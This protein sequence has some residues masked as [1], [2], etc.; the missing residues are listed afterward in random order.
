MG[1]TVYCSVLDGI[2][3]IMPGIVLLPLPPYLGERGFLKCSSNST[4]RQRT[5]TSKSVVTPKHKR[6]IM[7]CNKNND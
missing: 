6:K 3:G 1:K 4:L 2:Q 5:S 7:P